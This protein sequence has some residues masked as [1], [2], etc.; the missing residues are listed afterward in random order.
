M[1]VLANDRRKDMCIADLKELRS[2]ALLQK[3]SALYRYT[4]P[5]Q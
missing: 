2:F 3:C 5:E 4:I 1:E